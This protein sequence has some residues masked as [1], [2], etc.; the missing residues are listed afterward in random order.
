[1]KTF[2]CSLIMISMT[3]IS[4]GKKAEESAN[5]TDSISEVVDLTSLDNQAEKQLAATPNSDLYSDGKTK[6]IKTVDYRFQVDQVNKSTEAIEAA[7]RKFPAYISSSALHLEN[8]ILENKITIRVQSE[9]FQDLLKEIDKQ[10]RFVNFREVKTDD[11]AKE[12]VD[13][14]S[15]L[16]TKREVEKRYSE[17]L[18]TK[19][20]T[21]EELLKAEEQIGALHEDIEATISRINY[22][23]DQVHYSTINLEFYQT[24][25]QEITAIDQPSVMSQIGEGLSTGWGGLLNVIIGMAYI[26]PIFVIALSVFLYFKFRKKKVLLVQQP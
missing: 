5:A 13:L 21:I 24:I 17:I 23:K 14:D 7:V 4:C 8:P 6:L 10:A 22:L 12:F 20:G 25:T 15:R 26:W 2:I 16:N 11:V 19:A 1:M 9:Y 18:R 3:L